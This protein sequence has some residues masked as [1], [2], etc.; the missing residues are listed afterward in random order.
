M[1]IKLVSV[2]AGVAMLGGVSQASAAIIDATYTG[3]VSSG[4]DTLGLFGAAGA[5]LAGSSWVVTYTYDTSLGYSKS[6]PYENYVYGGI[7]YGNTSPV[8]SSMITINGVGKAVD[9]S[10]YGYILGKETGSSNEQYHTV[11][12]SEYLHN[13]IYNYNGTL[14][15]SITTPFTHT[16]DNNDTAYG[17]FGAG[18]EIIKANL[19]SL[20]VSDHVVA[21]VPE[22]STWAMMLLGFAGIGFVAYRRK[23][24]PALMACVY[25]KPYPGLLNDRIG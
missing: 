22:P 17:T 25:R 6:S 13:Y 8:L 1:N 12:S 20:T 10:Y 14:P 2:V 23:S 18:T 4:I 9:A 15:A 21:A 3:T 7:N 24:K 19:A 16:V 11:S 5:N